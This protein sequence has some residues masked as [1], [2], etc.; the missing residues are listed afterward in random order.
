MSS[1]STEKIIEQFLI[2]G[3]VKV[4]AYEVGCAG[5]FRFNAKNAKKNSQILSL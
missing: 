3:E 1:Q 4:R 2:S 5:L